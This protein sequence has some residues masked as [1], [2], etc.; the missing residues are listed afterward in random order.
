MKE[1]FFSD[2]IKSWIGK[3]TH[4]QAAKELGI[5]IWTFRGYLYGRSKP[6]KICEKCMIEKM[7]LPSGKT[8]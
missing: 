8:V 1:V 5:P 4:R 3:R 6:V 7:Q 2:R